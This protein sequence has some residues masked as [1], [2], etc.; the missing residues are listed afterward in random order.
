[1]LPHS[2]RFTIQN[3]S[4]VNLNAN[5]AQVHMRRWKRASDGSITWESSEATVFTNTGI[6]NAATLL[7]GT[8]Q[9]NS[10]LKWEGGTVELA[11][12]VGSGANGP[13]ILFIKR[14]TDGGTDFDDDMHALELERIFFTAA[15]SKRLTFQI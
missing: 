1:M 3:A 2:Y 13:V 12:T 10:S 14:S 5:E 6:F 8:I 9:D 11:V 4:T 7:D 15:G